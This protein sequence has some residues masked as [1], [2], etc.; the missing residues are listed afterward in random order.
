MWFFSSGY[1]SVSSVYLRLALPPIKG[2]EA[3]IFWEVGSL[4][5]D[6]LWEFYESKSQGADTPISLNEFIAIHRESLPC[7]RL[8]KI[9]DS[10]CKIS[11][12]PPI[13]A[14]ISLWVSHFATY[15]R[16]YV[17]Y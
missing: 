16:N 13:L 4:I 3:R 5:W 1:W 8:I 17:S 14:Q 15:F 6:E 2:D 7:A 11:K 9:S 10:E 12:V